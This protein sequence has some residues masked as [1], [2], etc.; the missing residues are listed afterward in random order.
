MKPEP[1]LVRKLLEE[2]KDERYKY[3]MKSGVLHFIE[4]DT[5]TL[6]VELK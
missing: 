5:H 2:E 4:K 1:N 3:L 6:I